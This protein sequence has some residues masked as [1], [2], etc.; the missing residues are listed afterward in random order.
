MTLRAPLIAIK[1][2]AAG[3]PVGYGA[4]WRAPR[5]MLLGVVGIGYG[6]GYP[7]EIARAAKVLLNG[8]RVPVVGRV[9]MDMLTVDLGGAPARIGDLATLWGEGLPADEVAAWAGTL[10]YTLF[11]GVTTRVARDYRD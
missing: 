8:A 9:S 5:E 1:H 7:R 10:P 2:L 4:T 11:C 3:E 6:D